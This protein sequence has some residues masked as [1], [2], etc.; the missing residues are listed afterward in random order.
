[1]KRILLS[2]GLTLILSLALVTKNY[3][4]DNWVQGKKGIYSV[5][6]GGTQG[7][8]VGGGYYGYYGWGYY[9]RSSGLSLLGASINAS[10]EYKVWNF[11]GV[12]WQ[13]GINIIPWAGAVTIEI[14]LQ[15]KCNIH[16]LDAAKVSIAD[17]LDVYGGLGFGAGPAIL[18]AAGSG[19]SVYGMIHVGPQVGVR[20]WVKNN[21]G[22]FGEFG[23]GA[24]FIN[25]GVT[26]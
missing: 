18:T 9:G 13:T 26:F 10:G 1:M 12:G 19:A 24:T 3:A 15:A 14:P 16:I 7:I 21:L 11:I 5:G 6:V 8:N 25:A 2:A 17:K 22:V 4:Q 20:Y 23:W